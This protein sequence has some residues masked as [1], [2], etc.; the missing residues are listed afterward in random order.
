MRR[1]IMIGRSTSVGRRDAPRVAQK[2]ADLGWTPDRVISSDSC[3]T[4]ETW[5]RM[6]PTF[7]DVDKVVFTRTLYHAGIDEVRDALSRV[8]KKV[9]TV[10][11]I[12]HNPGWEE[13]V[14]AL[15]SA[16]H[17]MTTCNAAMLS[18]KAESWAEALARHNWKL[19]HFLR[20]KEM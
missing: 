15:T 17:R 3:R 13:V 16:D 9:K 7:G 8:K 20:P 6:Q 11:V 2:I 5:D 1:P 18:T 10:M 4:R 14:H 19:E 12:G